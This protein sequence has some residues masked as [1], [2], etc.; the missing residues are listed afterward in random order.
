MKKRISI[1]IMI[2]LMASAV[3]AQNY[4]TRIM[5]FENPGSR[6]I[7]RME[8][9]NHWYYRSL[10]EKTMILNTEGINR[11]QIRSFSI[12][13]PRNPQIFIIIGKNRIPFDLTFNNFADGYYFF[14][15]IE[16]EIPEDTDSIEVLC[17]KRHI[18]MR[19]YEME[20]IIPKVKPIKIPNRQINAHAGMIDISHNSTT[21]EYYTFNPTQVLR[22]THNNAR[23]GIVYVRARLTDRSLPKFSLWHNGQKVQEYEFSLARTTKYSA[24]GV[25][26]LTIGKKIDLPKNPNSSEYEF[27]AESN[28][29]FMARP[30]LLQK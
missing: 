8:G 13:K 25:K 23:D 7:R 15:D 16:F 19:A 4:R 24:Q 21:S 26:Y 27:R 10:P 12:E 14:E 9:T 3:L 22:F 30:V 17:Y 29:M 6:R 28:H 5:D 20:E 1:I 11:I 18:Y 2:C